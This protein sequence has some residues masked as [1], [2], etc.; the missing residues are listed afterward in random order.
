MLSNAK[1]LT[2]IF[3]ISVALTVSASS[4][5]SVHAT[6]T[7]TNVNLWTQNANGQ[8][9]QDFNLGQTV[10]IFFDNLQPSGSSIDVIVYD[11]NHNVVFSALSQIQSDSPIDGWTP[12]SAGSYYIYVNGALAWGPIAVQNV[13]VAPESPIGAL[14]A[15][16]M[17]F[18]AFAAFGTIK[19]RR[20]RT[21]CV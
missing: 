15:I 11:A 7:A 3:C 17:C 10:Y 12:A 8:Q 9:T 19:F 21:R 13:F 18:S 4:L 1:K 20:L 16:I 14:M 5:N 6:G 2:V